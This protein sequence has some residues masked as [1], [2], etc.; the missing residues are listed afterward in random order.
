MSSSEASPKATTAESGSGAGGPVV[1]EPLASLVD[2]WLSVA[3]VAERLG[4]V[5]SRV[6]VMARNSQ[7]VIA[8]RRREWVPALF[9]D[10]P[11]VL[12]GLPGTLTLLKDAGYD[13][14]ESVA[15]LYTPDDTLPG[16]PVDAL[17]E[18]RGTEVRRR[19][20]ALGF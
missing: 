6:H 12:K 13:P 3:D 8:G 5:P 9:L 4:V 1:D 15:W 10:G 14:V 11:A 20:Q 2:D 19:A 17:V 18:N 16:R 7:L